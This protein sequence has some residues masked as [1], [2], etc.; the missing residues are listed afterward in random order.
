MTV[1]GPD[2]PGLVEALAA[3]VEKHQGNWEESRMSRLA[4]YF[5][6]IVQVGLEGSQ[7]GDLE[8]SID[9][10]KQRGL[11]IVIV[12]EKGASTESAGGQK[13]SLEIVGQDQ[14]GIVH[15]ISK[16]LASHQI[17]VESFESTCEPAPW[18]GEILFRAIAELNC[19][20]SFETDQLRT[21]LEKI[22]A[23]LMVDFS[24]HKSL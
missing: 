17:N 1:I 5:A 20:E 21:D 10:L 6:G 24:I 14:E 2:Q 18:S 3:A 4:G 11:Q 12:N 15:R 13:I 8:R 16:T 7:L 22:A 23:D 19:P 9:E